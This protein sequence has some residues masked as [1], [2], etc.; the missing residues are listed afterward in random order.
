[1]T[2]NNLPEVGG[3]IFL[4]N[5]GTASYFVAKSS[6]EHAEQCGTVRNSAEHRVRNSAEH[7]LFIFNLAIKKLYKF[8]NFLKLHTPVFFKTVIFGSNGAMK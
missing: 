4:R 3:S 8:R 6:A 2:I 5:C 7:L 1:M